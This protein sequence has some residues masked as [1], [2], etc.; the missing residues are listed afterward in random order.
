[1]IPSAM[2]QTGKRPGRMV[3]GKQIIHFF[4]IFHPTVFVLF[5]CE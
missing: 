3:A 4:F 5:L 1:M 2:K